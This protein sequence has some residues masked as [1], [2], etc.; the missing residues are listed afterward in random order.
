[1]G[2]L[3]A[4]RLRESEEL[5]RETVKHTGKVGG[6]RSQGFVKCTCILYLKNKTKQWE[7]QALRPNA[8]SGEIVFNEGR[9][10]LTCFRTGGRGGGGLPVWTGL[11]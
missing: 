5:Y 10:F 6:T 7:K 8:A 2:G 11:R 4:E 3:W 1:M 9:L